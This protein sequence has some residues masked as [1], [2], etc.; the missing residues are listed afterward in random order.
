MTMLAL[1]KLQVN[2]CFRSKSSRSSKRNRLISEKYVNTSNLVDREDRFLF[3][4]S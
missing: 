3:N 1:Y 4:V 2:E